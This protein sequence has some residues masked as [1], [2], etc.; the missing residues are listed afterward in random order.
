MSDTP[1]TDTIA[2]R[3][4]NL[5]AL[6]ARSIDLCRELEREKTREALNAELEKDM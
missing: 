5:D 2:H 6:A 4:Y 1:R 3:G